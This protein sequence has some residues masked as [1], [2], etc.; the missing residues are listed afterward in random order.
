MLS[1]AQGW[2]HDSLRDQVEFVP[3]LSDLHFRIGAIEIL[4]PYGYFEY[5][6][7]VAIVE[8]GGSDGLP[9]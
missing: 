6:T 4:V 5:R 1:A 3:S 7:L 8:T 9:P 2:S